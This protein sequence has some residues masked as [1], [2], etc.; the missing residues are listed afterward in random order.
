MADYYDVLGVSR[1]ADE[2][3]I[4]QSY[5]KLARQFHP[6]LNPGNDEAAGKFKEINEAYE[7]LSNA[8]SREK[9]NKYGDQWKYADQFEERSAA[10][11]PFGPRTADFGEG[12]RVSYDLFGDVG[13]LF[14]GFGSGSRYSTGTSRLTTQVE[15][16]LEEAC[17]GT[18]R[19]IALS[20]PTGTRRFEVKIPPGVDTGSVVTVRPSKDM[21]LQVETTVLP[22]SR[23]RRSGANLYTDVNVSMFDALLGGETEVDTITGKVSLKIP[24]GSQN[25]Q[26]IRLSGRGMPLLKTPDKKGDL[27]VTLRPQLPNNLTGEQRDLVEKL[28]AV[29]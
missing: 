25:G 27:F 22:H 29:S 28:R 18:L 16:S 11:P 23:F 8:D 17:R 4:R 24:E 15:L 21:E 26:R 13:D 12:R 19:T 6:D 3:T 1:D 2:K 20:E 9:Y 7:V 10:G 5:R 14:G